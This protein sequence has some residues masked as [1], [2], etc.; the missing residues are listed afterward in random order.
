MK[1]PAH[2]AELPGN[3]ISFLTVPLYPAYKVGRG[4]CRPRDYENTCRVNQK[5]ARYTGSPGDK[6]SG[7]T[8]V[9]PKG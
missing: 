2:R 4:T 1:L 8:F 7:F 3:E 6:K 5:T 9:N